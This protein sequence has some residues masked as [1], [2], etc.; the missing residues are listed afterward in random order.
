MEGELDRNIITYR[1]LFFP[2][3]LFSGC[4]FAR[5]VQLHRALSISEGPSH[6]PFNFNSYNN[7]PYLIQ[8]SKF[9]SI[10]SQHF[11]GFSDH[12]KI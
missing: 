8:E 5:T 1:F 2:E 6:S 9:Q 3:E 10:R 7:N 12:L 11:Q 4:D